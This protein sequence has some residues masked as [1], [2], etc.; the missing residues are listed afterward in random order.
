[1]HLSGWGTG[2]YFSPPMCPAVNQEC[3]LCRCTVPCL[4]PFNKHTFHT[5]LLNC[6]V[7][8]HSLG[9]SFYQLPLQCPH[10][11]LGVLLQP[12]IKIL[13]GA[14]AA[15]LSLYQ[16]VAVY[17]LCCTN[18]VL[19]IAAVGSGTTWTEMTGLFTF[20]FIQKRTWSACLRSAMF[21]RHIF[22]YTETLAKLLLCIFNH[23]ANSALQANARAV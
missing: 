21:F 13:P 2:Y 7:F 6:W 15:I 18:V 19:T 9:G 14:F 23:F 1:M 17:A 8:S 12:E 3:L 4:L 20:P 5:C 10:V 16:Q 11:P 22:K